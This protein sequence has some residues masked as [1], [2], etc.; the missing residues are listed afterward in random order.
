MLDKLL[1]CV[2]AQKAGTSWL[3]N[4]LTLSPDIKFSRLKE[5][6]YLDMCAGLNNQLPQHL[7]TAVVRQFGLGRAKLF[8]RLELD[9]QAALAAIK[10]VLDDEW[11]FAQFGG[12]GGYCADFT[13]E[14]A[15]LSVAELRATERLARERKVIFIMRD[16]VERS[17]SAFRYYHQNRNVDI[18]TM[19]SREI[20]SLLDSRLFAAR[21][22]YPAVISKLRQSFNT[23]DVLFLFYEDVMVE[24]RQAIDRVC[25]F[26]HIQP[27]AL[28]EERLNRKV[29][30]S[31]GSHFDDEIYDYLRDKFRADKDTVKMELGYIPQQW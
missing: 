18:D 13:P 2:G 6:H 21:S 14:Y 20:R 25:E 15:L 12:H 27:F 28:P 24:K 1:L 19:S 22:D 4:M 30:S 9:E 31:L 11:Y 5:L 8:S 16:P 26:L 7:L 29:N 3:H 10:S 23:E 17:L